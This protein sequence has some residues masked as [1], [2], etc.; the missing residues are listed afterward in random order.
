M[1]CISEDAPSSSL[2][3]MFGVNFG[4]CALRWQRANQETLQKSYEMRHGIIH[5]SGILNS[6]NHKIRDFWLRR[7]FGRRGLRRRGCSVGS[8]AAAIPAG[9]APEEARALL[10]VL[11]PLSKEEARA[12]F[13]LWVRASVKASNREAAYLNLPPISSSGRAQTAP[14]PANVFTLFEALM[15]VFSQ[16]F[17]S[18]FLKKQLHPVSFFQIGDCAKLCV[19]LLC[20]ARLA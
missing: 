18:F 16:P 20:G 10:A 7:C 2:D 1:S 4:L 5:D 3:L 19:K 14:P 8:M 12:Y 11:P 9:G 6:G 13:E 15:S 17:D